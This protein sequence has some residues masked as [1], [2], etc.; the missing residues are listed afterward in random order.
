MGSCASDAAAGGALF[1]FFEL[2]TGFCL[3]FAFFGFP[4]ALSQALCQEAVATSPNG[5][6]VWILPDTSSFL[7]LR[8]RKSIMSVKLTVWRCT[9]GKVAHGSKAV[10]ERQESG[11]CC[12]NARSTLPTAFSSYAELSRVS[13]TSSSYITA[14]LLAGRQGTQTVCLLRQQP[15]P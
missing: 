8:N 7:L 14:Q 11:D 4:M 9:T 2:L 15:H 13:S 5:K 12:C 10:L 6:G 1:F 3:P